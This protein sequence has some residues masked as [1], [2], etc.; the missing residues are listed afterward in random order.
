MKKEMATKVV[1]LEQVCGHLFPIKADIIKD[2][3]GARP[4]K[5]LHDFPFG[6]NAFHGMHRILKEEVP[7]IDLQGKYRWEDFS[8]ITIQKMNFDLWEQGARSLEI[9]VSEIPKQQPVFRRN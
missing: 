4:C 3:D 6:K 5:W 2:N 7:V 9:L 8:G 1:S